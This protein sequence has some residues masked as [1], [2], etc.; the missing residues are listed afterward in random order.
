MCHGSLENN[1]LNFHQI[2]GLSK[3]AFVQC[4]THVL[5]S[6]VTDNS[7]LIFTQYNVFLCSKTSWEISDKITCIME[8]FIEGKVQKTCFRFCWGYTSSNVGK[9]NL[10]EAS[11]MGANLTLVLKHVC[12]M[13]EGIWLLP[14]SVPIGYFSRMTITHPPTTT[15]MIAV[16]QP[17]IDQVRFVISM[18]AQ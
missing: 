3:L 8:F 1:W 18:D 13:F 15:P 4:V 7:N 17:K 12:I 2:K 14:N 5:Y 9:Q 16:Y 6:I 10:K 11:Y